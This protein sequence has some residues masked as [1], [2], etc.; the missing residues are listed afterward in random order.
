MNSFKIGYIE[1][2]LPIVQGGM[3]VAVSLSGLASAVAN[4][5]GIGVISAAGI[6][7]DEPDYIKNFYEANK[8]ALRKEIKKARELS[9]GI[10]G[11]NVMMALSD[12][13]DLITTAIEENIDVIFIGAGLPLKIPQ[14]IENAGLK[15]HHTKLIPKVSSAK[16][17]RLIFQ[18]W[19]NKYNIVPDAVALEG[20]LAGGHLGFCKKELSNITKPLSVLVEE[21]VKEIRYF[22]D[23]FGKEIPVI[24]GGGINSGKDIYDIMQSGA[25]GVKIGTKFV[26]TF[27]CDAS[28]AF[29]E[30]Y[31]T[32]KEQDIVIIDSPVGLPGRVVKNDFVQQIMNGETKPFKC[33]WRCINTCNIKDAPFCIAQ[34][35]FNSAKGNMAEG[36]AFAG[37]KAYLATKIRH[38]SEVI[39]ELISEYNFEFLNKQL[40]PAIVNPK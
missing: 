16:A 8:R 12:H 36:F 10:I 25:K 30:S 14:V 34:V 1:V 33:P 11:L 24:A 19:A 37:A 40:Y 22:E 27:E 17:A 18:Y 29:K 32:S 39:E 7:M 6:G 28:P 23:K 2:K 21:T 9:T 26:T 5:G 15:G 38:V 35:L 13:E 3:G 4:E 20:P 31:L